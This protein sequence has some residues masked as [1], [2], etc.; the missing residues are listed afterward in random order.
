M[1]TPKMKEE[2]CTQILNASRQLFLV[3]VQGDTEDA[4]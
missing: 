3:P 2:F 4:E 1:M